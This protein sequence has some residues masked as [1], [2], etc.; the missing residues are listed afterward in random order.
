MFSNYFKFTDIFSSNDRNI[1]VDI[2]LPAN[3]DDESYE[4]ILKTMPE[5][6]IISK[7][8]ENTYISVLKNKKNKKINYTYEYDKKKKLHLNKLAQ[9]IIEETEEIC[10]DISNEKNISDTTEDE[11]NIA[12]FKF[13]AKAI[14]KMYFFYLITSSILLIKLIFENETNATKLYKIYILIC[15]F[16]II[17]MLILMIKKHKILNM[18][19]YYLINMTLIILNL[20]VIPKNDGVNIYSLWICLHFAIQLQYYIFKCMTSCSD[21]LERLSSKNFIFNKNNKCFKCFNNTNDITLK[22]NNVNKMLH[23]HGIQLLDTKKNNEQFINEIYEL[24]C[25]NKINITYFNSE[26][27]SYVAAYYW[28]IKNYIDMEKWA[29]FAYISGNT[30]GLYILG[31]Y[32]EKNKNI[33]EMVKCYEKCVNKN[34]VSS[35]YSLGLHYEKIKNYI[36]AIKMYKNASKYG[37]ISSIFRLGY[38]YQFYEKNYDK[39]K[40][41]YLIAIDKGDIASMLHLGVYYDGNDYKKA[42]YFYKMAANTKSSN[43]FLTNEAKL[44]LA[45]LYEKQN[46]ISS[47]KHYL[48]MSIIEHKNKYAMLKMALYYKNK[49][50]YNKMMTYYDMLISVGSYEIFRHV[51]EHYIYVENDI[52]KML[53]YVNL[54]SMVK[55]LHINIFVGNYYYAIKDYEKMKFYYNRAIKKNIIDGK[56]MYNYGKYYDTVKPDENKKSICYYVSLEYGYKDAKNAM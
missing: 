14:I 1:N 13:S 27:Y 20:T 23:E 33:K 32:L 25:F 31:F 35:M 42:E 7:M 38:I 54:A 37:S 24:F 12:I 4:K 5:E 19:T 47:M 16:W 2:Y 43:S 53:H 50:K 11:I 26:Y 17:V 3:K 44:M 56:M 40:K 8:N 28:T 41:Y 9:T 22:I 36:E 29:N 39:M 10:I 51:C 18:I 55:Y 45:I 21:I 52:K 48:Q 30:Y 6:N 46:N 49:F 34:C 15:I